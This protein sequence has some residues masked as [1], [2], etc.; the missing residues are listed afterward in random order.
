MIQQLLGDDKSDTAMATKLTCEAAMPD[1]EQKMKIWHQLTGIED[2]SVVKKGISNVQKFS[3]QQLTAKLGGLFQ[4][5]QQESL[6]PI[7]DDY[8]KVIAD[9][10]FY[11]K[12]GYKFSQHFLLGLLPTSREVTQDHVEQ[13]KKI[14]E[15]LKA[16]PEVPQFYNK[17]LSD[18]TEKFQRIV[19]L[20]TAAQNQ[21][22]QFH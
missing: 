6:E 22:Q 12:Q 5:N 8:F 3:M 18:A 10:R 9:K 11:S 1:K 2:E 13:L 15:T 7:F 16:D 14:K 4:W 21:I 20:R 19:K 17:V